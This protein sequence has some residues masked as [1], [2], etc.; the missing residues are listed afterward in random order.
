MWDYREP[1]PP[2]PA[3]IWIAGLTFLTILVVLT[4][5]G[6][7][8]GQGAVA[9]ILIGLFLG[10]GF[11]RVADEFNIRPR[12]ESCGIGCLACWADRHL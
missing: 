4:L 7:F 8:A 11:A 10:Y 9:K 6:V 3:M 12:C 2:L 5:A 1:L